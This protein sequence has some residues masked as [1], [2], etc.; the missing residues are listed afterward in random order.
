[1]KITIDDL[2]GVSFDGTHLTIHT[3]DKD[4]KIPTDFLDE[5]FG[6]SI[7]EYIEN[8]WEH[9]PHGG[10]TYSEVNYFELI[11]D[12]IEGNMRAQVELYNAFCESKE[13]APLLELISEYEK[14]SKE[15][16]AKINDKEQEATWSQNFARLIEVDGFILRLKLLVNLNK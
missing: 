15:L 6:D 11:R 14:V 3:L 2:N 10:T 5:Y 1:M 7:S 16:E 8:E 12:N 4:L 13:K 9:S